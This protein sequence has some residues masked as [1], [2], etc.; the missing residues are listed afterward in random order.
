MK[1]DACEYIDKTANEARSKI[2]QLTGT[3]EPPENQ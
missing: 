3:T 1:Q 2:R